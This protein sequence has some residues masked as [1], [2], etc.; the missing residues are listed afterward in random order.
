MSQ[1]HAIVLLSGGIDSAA[2][3]H[4]L[5]AQGMTVEGIFFDYGQPSAPREQAAAQ[6]I[7]EH[8]GIPLSIVYVQGPATQSTGEITG[9]NAFLILGTMVLRPWRA[10]I[11]AL[12]IHSG[13]TYYDCSAAF[14]KTWLYSSRSIPMAPLSSLLPSWSG[15]KTGL[16]LLHQRKACHRTYL[17]LRSGR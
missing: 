1:P 8:I 6:L 13:N 16:R 5:K 10:G 3:A 17:Q 12:G 15:Q 14:V 4:L 2:C 9:R 11:L 7:A